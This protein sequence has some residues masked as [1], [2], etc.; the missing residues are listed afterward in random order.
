MATGGA[1]AL[2]CWV[3]CPGL[4]LMHGGSGNTSPDDGAGTGRDGPYIISRLMA[5]GVKLDDIDRLPR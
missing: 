3:N 2:I 1:L 4:I 5:R